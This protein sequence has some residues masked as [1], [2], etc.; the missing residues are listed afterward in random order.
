M[1]VDEQDEEANETDDRRHFMTLPSE[2]ERKACY[3]SFIKATSNESLSHSVCVVCA[4]EVWM[5]EGELRQV[6]NVPN[7]GRLKPTTAH[8]SHILWKGILILREHL[9]PRDGYMT[10]P[11]SL[12]RGI[13]G[14]V[15]L[16]NMNTEAIVSMLEGQLMPQPTVELASILAITYIRKKKLPSSWLKS[17]FRVRRRVVY[18]A[19]VWLKANNEIYQDIQISQERLETL[20][21]D[22]IP[23]EILAAVRHSEDFEVVEKEREG[24][25]PVEEVDE[26]LLNMEGKES[27][28]IVRHGSK[29]IS[30]FGK[31][32]V[33]EADPKHNPLAAAYPLLFRKHHT[34]PFVCFAITQ[35]RDAMVSAC[36]QMKRKDFNNEALAIRSLT[37][38]DLKQA[39]KEEAA[40]LPVTNPCVHMLRKHV[41]AASGRV[42]GSD[43]HCATYRGEVWG[44]SLILR[45]PSLWVTI[46]PC[47]LHDPVV[48]V[49]AGEEIDMDHF[50]QSLGPNNRVESRTGILGHL[51]GYY[52]VVEAQGRG[53]LHVHMLLWLEG[54]PNAEEMHSLLQDERFRNGIKAFIEQNI[55]AHVEGL[56]E[57]TIKHMP[58]EAQI[59]YSRPPNP[60]NEDWD[61]KFKDRLQRVVRSQQLHTCTRNTCLRYDKHGQLTCKHRAPW[62]LSDEVQ[63]D[64]EGQYKPLRK[65]RF[66][67]NFCPAISFALSCNNDI[68]LLLNGSDTK[69]CMWY[70]TTYQSKKQGKSFNLSALMAKSLLEMEFSAPQV[71]SYLMHWG[72]KICS[73]R[74][75]PLYWSSLQVCLQANFPELQ[76]TRSV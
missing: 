70:C 68:K 42:K 7:L 20:P 62:E 64:C 27:G 39:E 56:D 26:A 58:R 3:R 35:K 60:D 15:T 47:D 54:A 67:N 33:N 76:K 4:R 45:G 12:Q 44:T 17:T 72:D 6:I 61:D 71:I 14:N 18:G 2:E 10:N 55:Q 65:N 21:E 57:E 23:V 38:A 37:V 73:H 9:Y 75:V 50:E 29:P 31:G 52:G 25:V 48:Q 41:L 24:Y 49:F 8:H 22:D 46:N 53:T 51:S 16:Y 1:N 28:Y 11:N 59:A 36:I 63:L 5:R 19:L 66:M 30:E 13:T 43:S 69:D 34:F 74:Y 32:R 40:N